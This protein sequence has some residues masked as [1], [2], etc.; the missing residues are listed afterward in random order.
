MSTSPT[1]VGKVEIH[2]DHRRL[3]PQ[4]DSRGILTRSGNAADPEVRLALNDP[5]NG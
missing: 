2:Q 4:T 3:L 5:R 1:H